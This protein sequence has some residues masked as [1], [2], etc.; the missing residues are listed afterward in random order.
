MT[1]RE[2]NKTENPN[3]PHLVDHTTKDTENGQYVSKTYVP[4]PCARTD[5][6]EVK[7]EGQ[8]FY[9]IRCANQQAIFQKTEVKQFI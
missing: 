8:G 6:T 7:G 3:S 9:E 2:S 4:K 1:D 5:F